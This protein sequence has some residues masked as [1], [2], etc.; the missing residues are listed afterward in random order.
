MPWPSEIGCSPWASP[1][2]WRA[3]SRRASSAPLHRGVG[4]TARES[5]LQTDAAINPGNSGGPLVN[6]DGEV[7]GI[8]TAI[9]SSSGG[10]D[11]VGFAVPVN[12]ASWV[13]DQ[14]A[15]DGH[16]QRAY[17]G[18][19][20]QPVTAE[21]AE[22]FNVKP[23]EGVVVTEVFPNTPA[24]KAGLKSGDVIIGFAGRKGDQPQRTPACRGT[25]R[26]RQVREARRAARRQAGR[27]GVPVG[28]AAQ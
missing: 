1:S 11:G 15:R 19:G 23:R 2:V 9:S 26:D 21:L 13:A 17:L 10:N 22:K 18:V 25:R 12:L 14:L 28:E 20:I 24:A 3:P 16:V 6:L 4:I 7:I 5:F 8:N 27:T